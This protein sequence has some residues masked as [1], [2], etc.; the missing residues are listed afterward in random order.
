M[1]RFLAYHRFKVLALQASLGVSLLQL[2]LPAGVRPGLPFAVLAHVA[3]DGTV[4]PL[5]VREK[6]FAVE[7]DGR[8]L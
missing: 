3:P 7:L 1:N 8:R 5:G 4:L 6:A 2:Q